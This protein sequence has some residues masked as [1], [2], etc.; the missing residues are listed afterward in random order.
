MNVCAL[1]LLSSCTIVYNQEGLTTSMNNKIESKISN[2]NKH[3]IKIK[4][5][6]NEKHK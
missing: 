5:N 6:K 2:K 1:R 3:T 4:H